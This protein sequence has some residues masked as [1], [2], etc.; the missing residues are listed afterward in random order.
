MEVFFTRELL[1]P[2]GFELAY[3][4]ERSLDE[5]D[6]TCSLQDVSEDEEKVKHPHIYSKRDFIRSNWKDNPDKVESYLE[7][8]K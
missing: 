1:L 6:I 5:E 4:L 8:L 2:Q 7:Q 3:F